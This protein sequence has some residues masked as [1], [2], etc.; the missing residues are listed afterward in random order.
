LKTL[1]VGAGLAGLYAALCLTERGHDV[2]LLEARDRVGGRVWSEKLASGATAERG[3]E[4]I[5][6]GHHLVRRL[7]AEF[8]LPLIPSGIAFSRRETNGEAPTV[9]HVERMIRTLASRALAAA[10]EGQRDESLDDVFADVVGPRFRDDPYYR[11]VA[12]GIGIDPSLVSAQA[13]LAVRPGASSR[14]YIEHGARVWGG[15]Q[16]IAEE[17]AT[18]LEGRVVLNAPVAA[19]EQDADGVT[20]ETADGNEHR[21]DTAVVAVP[22][23]ILRELSATWELPELV[24]SSLNN[25]IMGTAAKLSVALAAGSEPRGVQHPEHL[26]W[27]WNPMNQAASTSVAAVTAYA[28]GVAALDSLEVGNGD[29]RW[30]AALHTLRSDLDFAAAGS[31]RPER[32]A[33]TDW[34]RDEWTRG[35]YSSAGVGWEPALD[36]AFATPVG[37]IALAGEHTAGLARAMEGALASGER[38]ARSLHERG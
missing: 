35:S 13:F 7:C 5:D 11:R 10:E 2:R 22:L 15:N 31:R 29:A 9:A 32:S 25:R 28:G 3:G 33:L 14:D 1:V 37:R 8:A 36:D 12:G 19:V 34:S 4:F 21:A 20:V 6:P 26:W 30:A 24:E 16:R 18:R 27:A 17:L 23:P 38:A